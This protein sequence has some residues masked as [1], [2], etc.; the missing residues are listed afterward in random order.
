[1]FKSQPVIKFSE[2]SRLVPSEFSNRKRIE[3]FIIDLHDRGLIFFDKNKKIVTLI[4]C[5]PIDSNVRNEI[6]DIRKNQIESSN[7][8]L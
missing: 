3:S 4:R 6:L 2:I 1:M 7:F 5:F 8:I